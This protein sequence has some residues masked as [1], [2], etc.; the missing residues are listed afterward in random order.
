MTD[1]S[2]N[3]LHHFILLSTYFFRKDLLIS[4]LFWFVFYHSSC[5]FLVYNCCFVIC[6]LCVRLLLSFD[7]VHA[8]SFKDISFLYDVNMLK[9]ISFL[10]F[11]GSLMDMILVQLI[12][13]FKFWLSLY[14][15]FCYW[16]ATYWLIHSYLFA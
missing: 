16:L 12:F 5:K 6:S 14:Y 4:S 3:I 8:M 10:R 11:V 13:C 9:M 1:C 2:V 7:L 15:L